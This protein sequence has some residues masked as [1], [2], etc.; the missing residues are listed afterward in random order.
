[1]E[2]NNEKLT[3]VLNILNKNNVSYNKKLDNYFYKPA[4]NA[5]NIKLASDF[6]ELLYDAT[7]YGINNGF[8]KNAKVIAELSDNIVGQTDKNAYKHIKDYQ[9]QKI[10]LASTVKTSDFDSEATMINNLKQYI[11]YQIENINIFKDRVETMQERYIKPQDCGNRS[12]IRWAQVTDDDG[13]GLRFVAD[14]KTMNFTAQPYRDYIIRDAK[15]AKEIID[16]NRTV[17]KLDAF[18]RGIGSNSCGPDT[19]VEYRHDSI[20]SIEYTFRIVPVIK[21]ELIQ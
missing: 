3:E 15:H 12:D 10:R 9:N 14:T 13:N 17:V 6:F 5:D 16:E 18:V 1:M 7:I 4:D 8:K 2:F 20:E 11:D 19:R 21:G